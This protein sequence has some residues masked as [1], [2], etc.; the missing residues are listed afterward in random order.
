MSKKTPGAPCESYTTCV[1][2]TDDEAKAFYCMW[3]AA[4]NV[5]QI[6]TDMDKIKRATPEDLWTKQCAPKEPDPITDCEGCPINPLDKKPARDIVD[7]KIKG[8]K[9][10]EVEATEGS[11]RLLGQDPNDPITGPITHPNG[12]F[13]PTYL[14]PSIRDEDGNIKDP[15]SDKDKLTYSPCVG[16][17]NC[18][19][20]ARFVS[21]TRK[22]KFAP[23]LLTDDDSAPQADEQPRMQQTH[24]P[25]VDKVEMQDAQMDED[26][27][28][29]DATPTKDADD[30]T[31]NTKPSEDSSELEVS[32]SVVKDDEAATPAQ[33]G[34]FTP[35]F[36][37][38]DSASSSKDDTTITTATPAASSTDAPRFT[39]TKHSEFKGM[40]AEKKATQAKESTMEV[41]EFDENVTGGKRINE[42]QDSKP[43]KEEA[44]DKQ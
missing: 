13:G 2:C 12:T 19:A 44:D 6:D 34:G 29:A 5:C 36:S 35:A 3:S 1:E 30:A 8:S 14:L 22:G 21:S 28:D 10:D 42:D 24:V 11:L 32:S 31:T 27:K 33:G 41:T 18:A 7:S 4:R 9:G 37:D 43:V 38:D 16:D 25:H 20:A 17:A 23:D 26:N 39:Q 40:S 15:V